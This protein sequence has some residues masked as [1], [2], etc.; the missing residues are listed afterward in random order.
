MQNGRDL[1]L[2]KP[3]LGHAKKQRV[4]LFGTD[5]R[6]TSG[7]AVR[8]A[9]LRGRIHYC[10]NASLT[11]R[12]SLHRSRRPCMAE[13]DIHRLIIRFSWVDISNIVVANFLFEA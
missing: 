6:I 7:P 12:F 1:R 3:V 8:S 11:V 2:E 13:G 4:S 9:V 10:P 5:Q